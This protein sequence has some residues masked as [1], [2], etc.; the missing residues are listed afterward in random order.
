M[1]GV[2]K[3]TEKKTNKKQTEHCL[4]FDKRQEEYNTE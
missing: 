3:I 4:D 1:S 2:L